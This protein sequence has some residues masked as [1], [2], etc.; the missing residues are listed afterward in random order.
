MVTTTTTHSSPLM[1]I[2]S[3]DL[4]HLK[5]DVMWLSITAIKHSERGLEST[6]LHVDQPTSK[7]NISD[8]TAVGGYHY[9]ITHGVET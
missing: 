3:Q 4:E 8:N 1:K 5:L 6:N 9:Q 2:Y 7:V